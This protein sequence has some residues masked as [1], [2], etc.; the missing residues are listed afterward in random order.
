LRRWSLRPDK[1]RT[2]PFGNPTV[3]ATM[4]AGN[5]WDVATGETGPEDPDLSLISFQSLSGRPIA[6]LANFSMHYFGDTPLSADYYGLFA[7]GLQEKLG[8]T[9]VAEGTPGFV[10]IMSHGCSGDIWL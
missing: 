2:D 6:L 1:V 10:G 9:D 7:N 8:Q 5:D 3:R 4:H